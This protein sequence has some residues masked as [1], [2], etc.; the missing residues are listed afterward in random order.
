MSVPLAVLLFLCAPAAVATILW[1]FVRRGEKHHKETV[2][3]NSDLVDRLGA[4]TS[5][6]QDKANE[7]R[8][9]Y[10]DMEWTR[11]RRRPPR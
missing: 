2:E 10:D 5:E 9:I 11:T 3:V 4:A 1:L 8:S 6:M 7:L